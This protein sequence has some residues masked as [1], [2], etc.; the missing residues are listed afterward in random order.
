MAK[1]II[2]NG[3][4]SAGKSSLAKTI[5]AVSQTDWLHVSLDQFIAMLPDGREMEPDW[6][7]VAEDNS[8]TPRKVSITNGPRG[9]HLMRSMRD[10]V[11]LAAE[12]ELDV[13]VDDVG[14]SE[15][16]AD[17][18]DELSSHKLTVVKVDVDLE[19]AE[20]RERARGDRMMGLARQQFERIHEGIEYDLEIVNADGALE[21]CAAQILATVGAE[22]KR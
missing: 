3:I 17:Y 1:V 6:F 19:T 2:L 20:R 11:R 7:V 4:S 18:R 14:T 22:T 5:Q 21:D 15:E 10:F 9:A 8:S 13:V 12:R 16:M